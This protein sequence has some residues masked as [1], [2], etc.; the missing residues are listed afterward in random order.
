[1]KLLKLEDLMPE[2]IGGMRNIFFFFIKL[3]TTKVYILSKKFN[4]YSPLFSMLRFEIR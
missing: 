3:K 2:R 1:M 4:V